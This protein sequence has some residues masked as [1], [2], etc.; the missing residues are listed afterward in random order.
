MLWFCDEL[1]WQVNAGHSN[2]VKLTDFRFNLTILN[3]S[4][5]TNK[6]DFQSHNFPVHKL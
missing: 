2:K 1:C 4:N 3:L 5:I 6:S